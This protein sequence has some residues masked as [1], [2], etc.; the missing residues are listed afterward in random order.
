M[1]HEFDPQVWPTRLTRVF[2]PQE[3]PTSLTRK[4]DLRD[5]RNLAHFN[6]WNE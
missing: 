2:D 1:T 6:Q 3:W 4:N 5:Q